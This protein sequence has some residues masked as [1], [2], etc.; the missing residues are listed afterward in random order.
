MVTIIIACILVL[1]LVLILWTYY[2]MNTFENKKRMAF[3][4]T[5]II[6]MGILT[7]IIVSIN[8]VDIPSDIV[9]NSSNISKFINNINAIIFTA[10]NGLILLPFIGGTINKINS[11]EIKTNIAKKRFLFI[12]ILFIVF[13]FFECNYIKSFQNLFVAML[14]K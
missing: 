12:I 4:L 6:L 1:Y 11:N 14:N 3:I 7:M 13:L 9:K 5:G 8:K 2:N 10:I